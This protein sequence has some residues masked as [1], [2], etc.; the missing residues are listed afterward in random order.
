MIRPRFTSEPETLYPLM[1]QAEQGGSRVCGSL[2]VLLQQEIAALYLFRTP[3]GTLLRGITF[4][5][6]V[7]TLG[8][9]AHH[10]DAVAALQRY[11]SLLTARHNEVSPW[12]P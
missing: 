3:D 1:E 4:A 5:D 11:Q 12:Q 2:R 7:L 9:F 6:A 8:V 10:N